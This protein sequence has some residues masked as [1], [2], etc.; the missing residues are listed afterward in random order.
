MQTDALSAIFS[1]NDNY[2]K[3]Q[4]RV[5][6]VFF[7]SMGNN[8]FLFFLLMYLIFNPP[9]PVYFPVTLSG[10]IVPIIP[11][12]KPNQSDEEVLIWTSKAVL[13]SYSY[14][15]VNY[16]EEI[17]AASGFFTAR[18]W[19]SFLN[20]LKNSNNLDA[21]TA[22]H[23]VVSANLL[24]KPVI[25]HKGTLGDRLAWDVKVPIIATFQNPSEFSQQ[26]LYVHAIVVRVPIL[27]A[28]SGIGIEQLVVEPMK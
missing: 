27:N 14:S 11:L 15:Y 2:K 5:L 6:G 17:Q 21:V 28:P 18:G 16:H 7:I 4:R 9:A 8:I 19:N 1:R 26:Y 13:A 24:G 10:Y 22:R 23:M 25:E 12:D 3:N 20:A